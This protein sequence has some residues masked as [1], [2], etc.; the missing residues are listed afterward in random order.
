VQVA[1]K[2]ASCRYQ[3][4]A[5]DADAA[6]RQASCRYQSKS[7]SSKAKL[8]RIKISKDDNVRAMDN[9]ADSFDAESKRQ[10]ELT[11]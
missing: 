4:K 7:R 5:A 6:I 11:H 9:I 1:A 10:M 8:N 3:S 2:A